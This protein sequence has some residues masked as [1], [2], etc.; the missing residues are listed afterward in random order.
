L[1]TSGLFWSI[2]KLQTAYLTSSAL[3]ETG[4]HNPANGGYMDAALAFFVAGVEKAKWF[5]SLRLNQQTK[6][7]SDEIVTE[8]PNSLG[9][10]IYARNYELFSS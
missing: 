9:C 1:G 8:K 4:R 3:Q 6:E 2:N 10:N 5:L 7:S